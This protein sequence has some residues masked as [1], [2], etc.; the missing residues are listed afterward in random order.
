MTKHANGIHFR[1][2]KAGTQIDH[3]MKNEGFN[4][5]INFIDGFIHG[6]NSLNC[7]T[8][9]DKM[10]SSDKMNNRGIPA[11]PRDGA[12]VEIIGL[13]KSTTRW[14]SMGHEEY[15]EYFP[16]SG[17]QRVLNNGISSRVETTILTYKSWDKMIQDRF[18]TEFYISEDSTS[19]LTNIRNIYKDVL[20]STSQWEDYQLRPNQCIAMMVAPELFKY[21]HAKNA[22]NIIEEKLVGP[23]GMKTLD[24]SD[25]RYRP[26]YTNHDSDDY[27]TAN[28]FNYHQGPVI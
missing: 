13:L 20:G 7:G 25:S 14:L 6:G 22:L 1:E 5:D 19:H 11:T 21:E 9:M 10:G 18:E 12:D 17:V 15:P 16:Y 28:G 8:W 23:L 2:W 3:H 24:D 26:Y 4:I 27:L